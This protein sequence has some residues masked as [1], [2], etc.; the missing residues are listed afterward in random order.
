MNT[1]KTLLL[2][3]ALG[4]MALAASGCI[5]SP[6]PDPD[7]PTPDP[8]EY[9]KAFTTTIMMDNFKT[10]YTER[11]IDGYRA[12]LDDRFLF[13]FTS[14]TGGFWTKEEDL[15]STTNM[16]SGQAVTNSDGELTKAISSIDVDQLIIKEAWTPVSASHPHFGEIPGV[17]T[18]LYQIRFVLHHDQGT[19]TVES[20][21]IF[22]GVP[23]ATDQG[24][25]TTRDEWF[26][27][28]QEDVG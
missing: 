25:G 26:L 23:I 12:L 2:V 13:F 27:I 24:D 9:P 10:T 20:D 3:L 22:Y 8:V 28:G 14:Q 4:L 6:D 7:P 18:A 16:F 11:D 5:F 19:I 21:Q 1:R 15:I 17:Q